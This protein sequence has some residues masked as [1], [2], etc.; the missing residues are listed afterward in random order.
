ML[1]EIGMFSVMVVVSMLVRCFY[2]WL[3]LMFG[4]FGWVDLLF[5]FRMLVF[6][7]MRC[8]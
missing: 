8:L 6:F 1:I 3:V 7:V 5:R 2:L 4:V